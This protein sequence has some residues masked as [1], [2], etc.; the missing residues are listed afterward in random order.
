MAASITI[1]RGNT[2]PNSAD[3]ADFYNLIDQATASISGITGSEIDSSAA[4]AASKLNLATIA[5]TIAMSSKQFLT[6]KGAD[7]AS[8]TSITLGTDGNCFDITGTTNIQTIT[9]KQA[10]SVV[11]LHFD[12]ALTLVDD[13]GN[14]ELQGS[15]LSVA[16]EDEVILKSDGTNWHLVAH[17]KRP[18]S[19]ASGAEVK[20]GTEAAK[21]VAPSTV[22]S[23]EGVIKAWA[24]FNGTGTP[25]YND[26]FNFTGSITDNGTGN[27]TLS[28]DTDFAGTNYVVVGS[29]DNS[30]TYYVNFDGH[31]AGTVTVEVRDTSGTAA[32]SDNIMI[33]LIGDR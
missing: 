3:K 19:A 17:S 29:V 16:A 5:Q 30:G 18:V 24:N 2:L 1:T 20:T 7:V 23:H 6:A 4:I 27:Y 8:A 15:S 22:I 32:D 12:G 25:A 21:Y 26:S 31:A 33:L 14:L 9:I 28:I 10:G 13:T 11:L